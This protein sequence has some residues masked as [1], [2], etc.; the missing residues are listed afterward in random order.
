MKK[1]I[2]ILMLLI[3]GTIAVF[4]ACGSQNSAEDKNSEDKNSK[5][6]DAIDVAALKDITGITMAGVLNNS[7]DSPNN[8]SFTF[9][10]DSEDLIKNIENGTLDVAA[11]PTNLAAALYKKTQGNIKVAAVNTLGGLYLLDKGNSIKSPADLSGCKV[12]MAGKNTAE[13]YAFNY[14]LEQNALYIDEN[15]TVDLAANYKEVI[16]KAQEGTYDVVVLPEPFASFLNTKTPSFKIA[17]NLGDEWQKIAG[18]KLATNCLIVQKT[19]AE[20]NSKAFGTFMEEYKNSINFINKEPGKA[21][22]ILEDN[23]IIKANI[24]EKAIPTANIVCITG[25]EMQ[26]TLE[27]FYN[28]LFQANPQSLGGYLPDEDFYLT[29]F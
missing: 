24:A 9:A 27:S 26:K 12:L 7:E 18:D 11:I 5:T 16:T 6:T 23:N 3:F 2:I 28:T 8:Y 13:E 15:I 14:L 1:K 4:S 22:K 20:E 25:N 10:K 21:G 17:L 29:D 19:F